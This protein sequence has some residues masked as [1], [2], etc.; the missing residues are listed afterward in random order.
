MASRSSMARAASLL[1]AACTTMIS[2]VSCRTASWVMG[3]SKRIISIINVLEK[4]ITMNRQSTSRRR[5]NLQ[6]G[7]TRAGMY[8]DADNK[9][10]QEIPHIADLSGLADKRSEQVEKTESGC[11]AKDKHDSDHKAYRSEAGLMAKKMTARVY[12]RYT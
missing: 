10:L 7:Q 3:E 2:A 6:I 11:Q 8:K 12:I 1:A 5:V 4:I 9:K